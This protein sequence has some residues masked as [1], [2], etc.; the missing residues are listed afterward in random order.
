MKR[1]NKTELDF[2]FILC[3]TI[4]DKCNREIPKKNCLGFN[5]LVFLII[6]T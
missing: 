6:A 3:N 5:I 2:S 1:V 4:Y